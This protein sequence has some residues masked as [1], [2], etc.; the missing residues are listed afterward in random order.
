MRHSKPTFC[1]ETGAVYLYDDIQVKYKHVNTKSPL[2]GKHHD[3]PMSND[4]D[5]NANIM[6]VRSTP[7]G[8]FKI[9]S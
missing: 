4:R 9:H 5:E 6:P 3:S 1:Y 8:V 2:F 7:A